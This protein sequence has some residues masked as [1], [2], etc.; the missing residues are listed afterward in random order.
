MAGNVS[1]QHNQP[2]FGVIKETARERRV[3]REVVGWRE[4]SS[5]EM[6]SGVMLPAPLLCNSPQQVQQVQSP[7]TEAAQGTQAVV[8]DPKM[9]PPGRAQEIGKE[10]L[11]AAG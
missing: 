4:G 2:I 3:H 5:G 1:Q 8:A 9:L 6:L 7:A 10:Q 11:P